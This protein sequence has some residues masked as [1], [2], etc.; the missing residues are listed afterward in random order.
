M[1]GQF[2]LSAKHLDNKKQAQEAAI[3]IQSLEAKEAVKTLY[4]KSYG[5]LPST[6]AAY[7][8]YIGLT[9]SVEEIA[10]TNPVAATIIV[11]QIIAQEIIARYGTGSFNKDEIIAI[12]CSEPGISS[13]NELKTIVINGS[14][15][16][17]K[18]ISKE[19]LNA[20]KFFIF[21]NEEGQTKIY[22][23]AKAALNVINTAKNI[24]GTEILLNQVEINTSV[25]DSEYVAVINDNFEA[26]QSI[27][28]T[29][30]AAVSLGVGHSALIAGI[31]TSKETKDG[32]GSAISNTQSIQFTLADLFA[33]LESG[34]M[35]TYYSADLINSNKANIKFA[36][37]AKVQS[38]DTAAQISL[39]S[40]QML[41]N[42]GY[43]ANNDFAEVMQVA[44]AGQVKGGTNRVQKN[45]IYQYIMAKK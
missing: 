9:I 24:A 6:D 12:L 37:M 21:A 30:I 38:S 28:R 17:K 27:A 4:A 8:D 5:L 44:I 25:S 19:Q 13:L 26:V 34:R 36:T 3:E 35:L 2:E 1:A 20:D 7:D 18:L 23:V 39:Q 16:G 11:D 43:I 33:E 29:L 42:L 31:Q 15:Q 22:S 45:Q 41:G 10:K 14:L 32:N 40:L